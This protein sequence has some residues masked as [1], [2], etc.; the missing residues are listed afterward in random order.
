MMKLALGAV[1]ICISLRSQNCVHEEKGEAV[2]LSQ[3]C[4]WVAGK[5]G[6][7]KRVFVR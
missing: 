3:R 5:G 1:N 6:L 4:H 7:R 2:E